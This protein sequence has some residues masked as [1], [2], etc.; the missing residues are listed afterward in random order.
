MKQEEKVKIGL[1]IHGYLQTRE[2]LFCRCPTTY[3]DSK[4]N[5][6]ICPICT[7]MP[8]SKPMLPNE[9]AIKKII[10]I[11]LM[12][13][14]RINKETIWQRKHY[15]WPDLPKGYQD[16][17]SGAYSV[18]I[19]VEGEFLGIKIT[20]CHIEE[21]PARWDPATGNVDYNRCGMPLVE[22]VTEPDF[23]DAKQVSNWLKQLLIV[24]S[25]IKAVDKDAGIKADVN[26][27]TFGERVEVKNVNSIYNI[28]RVIEHEILRQRE[29]MKLGK[30]IL[31]ETRA[32]SEKNKVT[33]AMRTKEQTEDYR[34]IPDPDLP[35]IDI[36]EELVD[37]I[38]SNL[39][40]SH[41]EK[42]KRFVREYNLTEYD[43][44]V[45]S[46]NLELAEFF[47]KVIEKK[48]LKNPSAKHNKIAK[49]AASWVTIELLRVLNYNKKE[50]DEVDITPEHFT[51]LLEMIQDN[52]ITE[53]SAKQ[54]LNRFIPK[55]FNPSKDLKKIKI[56]DD[57]DELTD[58]CT[59]VI[60]K[61]K[62]A[63]EDYKSGNEKA[64]FFLIGQV[65]KETQRRADSQRAKEVL[66]KL[67]KSI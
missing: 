43:S 46:S 48:D 23:K 17:A 35:V 22:I 54:I 67:L 7:A 36:D 60:K 42:I 24:L 5:T 34:Y 12:L 51:S 14:C 4:P 61:N 65:M 19:G 9:E 59:S 57:K 29:L 53:L 37:D 39:P 20:E 47:E 44:K 31:R 58:V 16:T 66:E 18:P 56:I 28:E 49:L 38:K 13:K 10:A 41:L 1:E 52:K 62:K 27:S 32:F 25:Y 26:V 3:K 8:G 64:I 50:L 63:A 30:E 55:S 33:I 2:K 15:D 21:D 6:N 40:E 11:A 45:L